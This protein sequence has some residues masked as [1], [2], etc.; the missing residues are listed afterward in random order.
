MEVS[1][2]TTLKGM[3]A[4]VA[5]GSGILDGETRAGDEP[6]RPSPASERFLRIERDGR[7]WYGRIEGDRI[8]LLAGPP[9]TGAA[10]TGSDVPLAGA[11]LLVP[12]EPSKV[13]AM[14]R[15]YRSHAGA[16]AVPAK[17][18]LFIKAPSALVEHEGAIVIPPGTDDV[19][20]EGE[21]V[22]V[23]GKRA[24]DIS[25][26]EAPAHVFGFTC[27][28][29]VSAR[30]WQTG[31]IQWW[32]AKA[33][34]TFAPL[35]PWIATGLDPRELRLVTRL[36]GEVKQES[37]TRDLIFDVPALVSFASR[38]MTL[39]PGDVI[40]TGTPGTTSRMKP[41]DVVE[42]EISGIGVLRNRVR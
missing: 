23:I 9:W 33:S 4:G 26:A 10:E 16:D 32:R 39:L 28:N 21:L 41:G 12:C 7:P 6:R 25:P 1:R 11:K 8:R 30:D 34:D 15:N 31:D 18:E 17:P 20:Y 22:V 13:L 37:P 42:V 29:D 14:A 2:R 40:Y 27:G 24:K 35:G 38:H 36:D 5:I 3:F 19:H